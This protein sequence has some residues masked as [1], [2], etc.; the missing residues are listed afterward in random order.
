MDSLSALEPSAPGPMYIR[1]FGILP[2]LQV[3]TGVPTTRAASEDHPR[4]LAPV[5]WLKIA[6]IAFL[7]TFD[8]QIFRSISRGDDKD[9]LSY[10]GT[11]I[12]LCVLLDLG[13][14]T[15]VTVALDPS[16]PFPPPAI[17]ETCTWPL[18]SYSDLSCGRRRVFA[19]K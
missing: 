11:R 18:R 6:A 19:S 14:E 5:S 9:S 2:I 7:F 8:V 1:K 15:F 13:T 17:Y 3:N 10:H 12:S 16:R 4:Q